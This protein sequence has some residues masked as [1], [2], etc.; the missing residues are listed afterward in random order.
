MPW[1]V[2]FSQH[3]WLS[4]VSQP[5]GGVGGDEDRADVELTDSGDLGASSDLVHRLLLSEASDS[6]PCAPEMDHLCWGKGLFENQLPLLKRVC[7]LAWKAA[8]LP[9][10]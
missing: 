9:A 2:Q 5:G 3:V 6:L 8:A 7:L 1:L 4:A 10:K